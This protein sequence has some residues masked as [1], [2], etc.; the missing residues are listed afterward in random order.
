MHD[1][2]NRDPK[3]NGPRH[4]VIQDA[5]HCGRD[6]NGGYDNDQTSYTLSSALHGKVAPG[7]I[8][9]AETGDARYERCVAWMQDL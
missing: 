5:E 2:H 8:L 4:L 7:K 3:R 1:R 9:T 6:G